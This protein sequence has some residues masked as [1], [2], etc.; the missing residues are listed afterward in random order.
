MNHK[1]DSNAI[2]QVV[3]IF[4]LR[5]G[6]VNSKAEAPGNQATSSFE[7]LWTSKRS[8][9]N[10]SIKH[11]MQDPLM[12]KK[13]KKSSTVFVCVCRCMRCLDLCGYLSERLV[14]GLRV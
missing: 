12:T 5:P 2:Q 8:S 6:T 4:Q 13:K 10:I 3:F 7:H 9:V 11:L 1:I 14:S